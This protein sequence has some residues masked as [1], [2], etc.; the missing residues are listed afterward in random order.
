MSKHNKIKEE[1]PPIIC[2]ICGTSSPAGTIVCT[3]G[4]SLGKEEQEIFSETEIEELELPEEEELETEPEIQES[5]SIPE[6]EYEVESELGEVDEEVEDEEPS[7]LKIK[8][9]MLLIGITFATFGILGIIMLRTGIAQEMLGYSPSP[10]IGPAESM[11]QI[12]SMI[13]LVIGM[14]LIGF[15]GI[16]NDPIYKQLEKL[17]GKGPIIQPEDEE[18]GEEV[19]EE[20][21]PEEF[22]DTV[23]E[24]VEEE[25]PE[26]EEII[27]PEQEIDELED[28][29][30]EEPLPV[31][32]AEK[33]QPPKGPEITPASVKNQIADEIRRVERCEKMLNAVIV[34]PDDKHKLK[35]LIASGASLE[36]FTE[37]VKLAVARR[38]KKEEEK[39]VTAEEKAS[40]LEDELVAELVDLE[41]ELL[42]N[43]KDKDLEDQILREIDELENL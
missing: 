1:E 11:A 18:E 35:E 41:D 39:D 4:G 2:E 14:V 32:K 8:I 12:G 10:G 33:I 34:L 13:P 5:E 38:K 19:D 30:V 23:E 25:L 7:P 26:P 29:R 36:K 43:K 28:L 37:E 24:V 15:W 6:A 21:L 20:E 40:I 42:D 31:K 17:K 9:T 27:T 3:C 16:R 22:I